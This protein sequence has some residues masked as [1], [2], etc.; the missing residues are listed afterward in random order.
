VG[1]KT[2]KNPPKTQ[3]IPHKKAKRKQGTFH[4]LY[5]QAKIFTK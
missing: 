5:F 4:K 1:G 3:E 2:G